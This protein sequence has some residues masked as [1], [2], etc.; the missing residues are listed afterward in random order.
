M[1]AVVSSSHVVSA[2]PSSSEGGPLTLCPCSSVGS[3][4]RDTVSMTCCNVG[5]SHG[6]Q[7]FTNC[8]SVGPLHGVQSFRNRLETRR[9]GVP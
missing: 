8:T 4:S 3:L 6:L 2:T 5:A 7:L 9:I 1:G